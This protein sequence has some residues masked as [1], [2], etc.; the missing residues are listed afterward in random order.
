MMAHN[1]MIV[2]AW[3]K[4]SGG[5]VKTVHTPISTGV[6]GPLHTMLHT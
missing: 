4:E 3:E 1:L 6:Y 2:N 5:F